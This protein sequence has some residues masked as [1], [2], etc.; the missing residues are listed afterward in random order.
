[1]AA[2]RPSRD[3]AVERDPRIAEADKCLYAAATL[4]HGYGKLKTAMKFEEARLGLIKY[5]AERRV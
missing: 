3:A 5:E 1:M 4:A 2:D